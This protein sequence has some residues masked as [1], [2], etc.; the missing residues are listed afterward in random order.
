VSFGP[1]AALMMLIFAAAK[2]RVHKRNLLVLSA[3]AAFA[4]EL[5]MGL[6]SYMKTDVIVVV[7]PL[8]VFAATR[9]RSVNVRAAVHIP[10]ARGAMLAALTLY[11][12]SVL[13]TYSS[14]RRPSFWDYAGHITKSPEV[15]PFLMKAAKAS[16]P[17]T[18]EFGELQ[19]FPE[20][21]MWS[22]FARN[23][24]VSLDAWCYAYVQRNG[25]NKAQFLWD[26]PA[27][28]IPRVLWPGKPRVSHGRDMAVLMGQATSWE[29]ATSA[30]GLSMAGCLY[31]GN[32]YPLVVLGMFLNGAVF[33]LAWKVFSPSMNVNPVTTLVCVSL[34][35]M[36]I[37]WHEA[38]FDANILGYI[39]LF[40]VFL[41]VSRLFERKATNLDG[42][43]PASTDVE[44]H[45][46]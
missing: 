39:F 41:P 28:L 25:T 27:S 42:A 6:A 43:C 4:A 12:V 20:G 5:W 1:A 32:A 44:G 33:F 19:R 14:L 35:V 46:S 45:L 16:I 10:V 29:S 13:F 17:G 18:R 38:A 30:T 31:L 21:G 36:G 2:A 40:L 34:F 15:T 23:E 7:L 9:L 8:L 3:A 26:V 24:L 37:R 22:F 11:G